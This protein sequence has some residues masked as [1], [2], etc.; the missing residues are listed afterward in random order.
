MTDSEKS[1]VPSHR[2]V[3]VIGAGIVG[4]CS[5]LYLQREGMRVTLTD[6]GAPGEACSA[7]NA[8]NLGI[9]SCVPYSLPGMVWKVPGL[10]MDP[11]SCAGGPGAP[12]PQRPA[13][14][15]A[16]P[17]G[18]HPPAGRGDRRRAVEPDAPAV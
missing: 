7:G 9:A 2:E 5:A 11:S 12:F 15:R 6:R 3:L 4:V 8:G 14:V 1:S 16:L 10:L 13:L 18:R 17:H